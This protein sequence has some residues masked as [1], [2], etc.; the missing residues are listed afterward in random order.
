MS[1][2][3]PVLKQPE[4]RRKG[5][6]KLLSILFLLFAVLLAVL[7]FNSSISK[8]SVIDVTGS[9]NATKAEIVGA[10]DIAIGDAFFG[11]AKE[12]LEKRVLKVKAVQEATVVKQFPGS[13][14]ISV[15]EYPV[16]AFEIGPDG[17]MTAIMSNAT[18]VLAASGEAL[19]DKPVLS[20]W[21]ADDPNKAELTK[22]LG[23]ISAKQLSD[24]SEIIPYPSKAYPDRIKMYTRTKFEVITSVSLLSEKIEALNAVIESQEPGKITMLLADTYVPFDGNSTEN[25]ETD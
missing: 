1:A 24:L 21:K 15:K 25:M 16:V 23:T 7:F 11:V 17:Q 5:S 19:L 14:T 20:G 10:A 18:S 6:R 22:Q 13:I 12:T 2:Q 4:R 9:V 8:I 3:M